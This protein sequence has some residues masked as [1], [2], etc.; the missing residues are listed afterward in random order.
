MNLR[1]KIVGDGK[2]LPYAL[3]STGSADT[4]PRAPVGLLPIPRFIFK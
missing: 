3:S 2:L 4:L 1:T